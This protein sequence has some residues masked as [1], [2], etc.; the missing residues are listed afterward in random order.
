M[1]T[2]IQL[3]II[4]LTSCVW[5]ACDENEAMPSYSKKGTTTATIA[6]LVPSKTSPVAGETITLSI[7][8]VNAAADPVKTIVLKAK[9]GSGE[10]VTLQTF[11]E[12][13]SAKDVAINYQVS[14]VTPASPATVTFEMAI[15]SQKEYAQ[16]KRANISVK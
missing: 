3:I 1:K 16:I 12:Q 8:Y 7:G 11:D 4:L 13:S 14:Y 9:V 10:Y 15:S 6:T 5:I 2:K